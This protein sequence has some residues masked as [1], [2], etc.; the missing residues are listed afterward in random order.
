MWFSC[1][2]L[3]SSGPQSP[4]CNVASWP[5]PQRL[6]HSIRSSGDMPEGYLSLSDRA[7]RRR[8]GS[9]WQPHPNSSKVHHSASQL[10]NLE[11]N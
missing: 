7:R 5:E 8:N 10:E 3:S 4:A 2:L 11:T 1:V 6:P 9:C